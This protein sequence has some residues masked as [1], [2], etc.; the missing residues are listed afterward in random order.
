[1]TILPPP[2]GKTRKLS[3]STCQMRFA[4]AEALIPL[5]ALSSVGRASRLHREG[6]RFEPVSA[7]HI[8][9]AQFIERKAMPF[10]L[11]KGLSGHLRRMRV[12]ILTTLA[13]VGA[14]MLGVAPETAAAREGDQVEAA[15][16]QC[17][18]QR[19]VVRS[20]MEP[21][22]VRKK[23]RDRVRRILM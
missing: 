20:M 2:T 16:C 17:K 15:N 11:Q 10:I 12:L 22:P 19:R 23:D 14:A 13:I 1:M 6:Q 7:H 18:P 8:W 3:V 9:M 5:G 21:T 4:L